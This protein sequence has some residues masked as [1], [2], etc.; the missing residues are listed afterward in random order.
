MKLAV[1]DASVAVKWFVNEADSDAASGLLVAPVTFHAPQLLL[2]EVA[3]ALCKNAARGFVPSEVWEKA[4]P[5]LGRSIDRWHTTE[6]LLSD[7]FQIASDLKHPIYDCVYLALARN[8][9]TVCVTADVR[10]LKK[11]AG[12]PYAR[13]ARELKNIDAAGDSL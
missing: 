2:L 11:L 13:L 8:L 1:I 4:R 12:S 9:A 3:S 10:L 6:H 5:E 7:A